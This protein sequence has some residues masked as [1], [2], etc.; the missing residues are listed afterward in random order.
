MQTPVSQPEW[1]FVTFN[2]PLNAKTESNRRRVRSHATRHY[3]QQ[4]RALSF[5][6]HRALRKDEVEVDITPLLTQSVSHSDALEVEEQEVGLALQHQLPHIS[7]G[8]DLFDP[9][10]SPPVQMSHG[11][12]E[13]YHHRKLT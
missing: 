5:G 11:D 8:S 7:P 6:G 4:S 12:F 3:H 9:F 10:F 13:L 1:Q 2:H